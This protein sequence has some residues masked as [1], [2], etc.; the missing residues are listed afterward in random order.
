MDS[1]SLYSTSSYASPFAPGKTNFPEQR[2]IFHRADCVYTPVLCVEALAGI[3]SGLIL[4][5]KCRG[6][7]R[8]FLK[9]EVH[10][11]QMLRLS[12]SLT[13]PVKREEPYFLVDDL[14]LHPDTHVRELSAAIELDW[15]QYTLHIDKQNFGMTL[16]KAG[17]LLWELDREEVAGELITGPLGFRWT[18]GRAEAYLSLRLHSDEQTFGFG[19]KFGPVEKTGFSTRIWNN[20]T[21]GTNTTDLSYKAIPW[22]VSSRGWGLLMSSAFPSLWEVGSFSHTSAS[23]LVETERWDGF[24][25]L[26]D[27]LKDIVTGYTR[28]TGLPKAVPPWALGIWMSRCAYQ[29]HQEVEDVVSEM[30]R[31]DIPFDVVHLDPPWMRNHYYQ[32]LGTDA[33]DFDWN[34]E[35][36]PERRNFFA[37]LQEQ[38]IAVSI[39]I[40]PYLPEGGSLYQYAARRGFL[41]RSIDGGWS[42]LEFGQ[43]VGIVD[44]TLR[45][46]KTWWKEL[47][48]EILRDGAAVVK[49]DYADRV[50]ET[51]LFAD[52]R[53]GREMHNTYLHLYSEAASEAVE[54]VH[55]HGLLWRRP[56]YIGTQRFPISWAGDTQV[57][58]EGLKGCLRGGLSAAFSGEAFWSHDIGGFCGPKPD[59]ELYIRW[60]QL[61]MFSPCTRF[62]GTSVREPWHFGEQAVEITRHYAKLRYRLIPYLWQCANISTEQGLPIMRPMVLEFPNEPMAA[63]MDDQFMLGPDLLVAPVIYPAQ[64]QRWVYLP[65]GSW[66]SLEKPEEVYEGGRYISALAPLNCIPAY[67]RAE[68]EL[69][70]WDKAPSH[71]KNVT[72]V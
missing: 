54:E 72:L 60:M 40:N 19:E 41:V 58:W 69:L 10:A 15:D 14:D 21:A 29:N 5:L 2:Q 7:V 4:A 42:R 6:G 68:K 22:L 26:G 25:I 28:L 65:Q 48:K 23:C 44:F 32:K 35:A 56:G 71:L 66:R 16:R 36:F 18:N 64:T 62:H 45:A 53:T 49:T 1:Q 57:S 50:P 47:I 38:G 11:S 17:A 70:Q 51:A 13:E 67:V 9:C 12:L 37:R 52:G 55:G 43:P 39:W 63:H 33:C 34:D 30:Q 31:H 46:A 20:D 8:A 27:Q 3:E 61:G 24:L 59:P